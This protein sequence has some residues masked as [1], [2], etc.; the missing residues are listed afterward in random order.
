ML[1]KKQ[2]GVKLYI[3]LALDDGSNKGF[4]IQTET[5]N[6]QAEIR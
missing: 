2:N 4:R 5:N 1:Y 3:L 6:H